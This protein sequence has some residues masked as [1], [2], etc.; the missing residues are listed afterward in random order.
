MS[1]SVHV[2]YRFYSATDEL[3]YIGITNRP[4]DR[5]KCHQDSKEWWA[6]VSRIEI[7][8]Y[9]SREELAAAERK[10]IR[11]ENPKFNV[12]HNGHRRTGRVTTSKP[13]GGLVGRFFH[14]TRE[15]PHGAQ[16]VV[17]QGRILDIPFDGVLLL[18]FYEW[19]MGEVNGEE[20][21]SLTDFMA[22]KPVLYATNELMK[23]SYNH[24][25]LAHSHRCRL[26]E[27]G[28]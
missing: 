13:A 5:F 20:L 16:V 9:S 1:T 4:P 8:N 24:G 22:R 15:C 17:L 12:Q 3:L 23:F 25:M 14:T 28:A 10:A 19:L 18:E 21:M 7:E 2:L 6:T 26:E 27:I 11:S